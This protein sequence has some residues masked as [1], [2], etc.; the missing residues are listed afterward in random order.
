M[1]IDEEVLQKL[2]HISYWTKH[3]SPVHFKETFYR[4]MYKDMVIEVHN[5]GAVYFGDMMIGVARA[6]YE[7]AKRNSDALLD[8]KRQERIDYFLGRED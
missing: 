4:T 6:V 7:S 1:K 5:D 3:T 8:I 2:L